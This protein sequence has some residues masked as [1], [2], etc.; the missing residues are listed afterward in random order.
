MSERGPASGAVE[1]A[2]VGVST[3]INATASATTTSIPL[4]I[5]DASMP[6]FTS[7][8][9]TEQALRRREETRTVRYVRF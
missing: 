5:D 8:Y 3:L 4:T 1:A 7:S 2:A 9:K 6:P